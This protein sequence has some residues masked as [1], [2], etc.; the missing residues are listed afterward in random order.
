MCDQ[1]L[2][3]NNIWSYTM[4]ILRVNQWEIFAK[5]FTSSVD[6]GWKDATHIQNKLL[7]ICLFIDFAC[8]KTNQILLDTID[9]KLLNY[10][11]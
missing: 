11:C 3:T 9:F 7:H 8:W 5:E 6:S 4:T 10:H 2:L 1:N